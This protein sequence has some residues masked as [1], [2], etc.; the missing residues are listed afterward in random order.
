M[1]N[2]PAPWFKEGVTYA[3]TT[4]TYAVYVTRRSEGIT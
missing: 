3:Q 1:T 2:K 4:K